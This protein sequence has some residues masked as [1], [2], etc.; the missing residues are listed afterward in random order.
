V[1]ESAEV[2]VA[3]DEITVSFDGLLALDG[4]SLEARAGEVL[5]LI[6]PNGAGKTTLMNVLSGFQR[7][8]SGR[9][10]CAG[11]DVTR[12][13]PERMV[14]SGIARTFQ[15]VRPFPALTVEENIEIGALG[16]GTRRSVARART[17]EILD[18]LS[19]ASRRDDAAGSLPLGEARRLGIARALASAPA[20]LLLDE[21][22]AGSNEAESEQLVGAL[23]EVRRRFECSLVVIEH[24]MALIM[25]ICERIHVLDHGK[26][27]A[28]GAPNEVRRD[29]AVLEAYLG[30]HVADA[31]AGG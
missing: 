26:S 12:W 28:E 25:S 8:T 5:G 6:G 10:E 29:P 4:V 9:V 14:R 18:A 1:T 15:S 11:R 24:D 17:A 3:A 27:I 7:P 30:H 2:L 16:V 21:P 19:L 13:G 20:A 31:H 22:A 23:L